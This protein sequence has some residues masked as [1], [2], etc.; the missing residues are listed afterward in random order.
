MTLRHRSGMIRGTMRRVAAAFLIATLALL[1]AAPVASSQPLRYSGELLLGIRGW[2]YVKL[3]KGVLT[4]VTVHCTDAKCPAVTYLTRGPRAR[5]VAQPYDGWKFT[6]WR[7]ACKRRRPVCVADVARVRPDTNGLRHVRLGA[8]F[9]P[10]AVGLTR[11]HPI[12]LGTNA[13]VGRG[14]RVRVNSALP[15]TQLYPP[16]PVGAEYLD[17]NVTIG[18]FGG[19]SRT[20]SD[21]LAWQVVGSHHTMYS[22]GSNPCPYPGPQPPLPTYN[23][24]Y[25]GQSV[26]GYVCWQVAANDA[27]SLELYFGSGSLN[28]PRTTWFALH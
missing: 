8:T 1:A 11:S 27:S 20:P 21:Y 25:T 14:W 10:V 26:T 16:P 7:G 13:D 9:V 4:H 3:G 17:A 24:I 22:P 12:P 5:L 19:G 2:G 15:D 6:G 28:Y 18:Y 23:P